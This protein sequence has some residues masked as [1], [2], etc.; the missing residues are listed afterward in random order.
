MTAGNTSPDSTVAAVDLLRLYAP[1]L[2]A[3]VQ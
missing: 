1:H 3:D 2:L